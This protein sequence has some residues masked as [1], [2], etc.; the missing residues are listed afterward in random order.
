MLCSYM[1][2][3]AGV[4]AWRHSYSILPCQQFG[5]ASPVMGDILYIFYLSKVGG[6]VCE[7]VWVGVCGCV[8]VCVCVCAYTSGCLCEQR[9]ITL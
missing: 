9:L 7:G 3:E 4:Q 2:V 1:C 8:C 5:H 6:W